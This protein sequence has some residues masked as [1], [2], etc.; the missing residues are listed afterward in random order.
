MSSIKLLY[1]AA[2]CL[3]KTLSHI[4]GD[5]LSSLKHL[6]SLPTPSKVSCKDRNPIPW[7]ISVQID[8][9][10]VPYQF[11]CQVTLARWDQ[12]NFGGTSP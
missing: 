12:D 8:P 6:S 2:P 3:L 4:Q 9:R 11:I 10:A 7:E 5:I 1:K